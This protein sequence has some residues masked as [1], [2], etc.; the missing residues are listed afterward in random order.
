MARAR[1]HFQAQMMSSDP[2][3]RALASERE[4]LCG[5]IE[6]QMTAPPKRGRKFELADLDSPV[7]ALV[8]LRFMFKALSQRLKKAAA[9]DDGDLMLVGA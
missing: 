2:I 8:W 1:Q 6:K 5:F 7:H 9:R 4:F 3:V